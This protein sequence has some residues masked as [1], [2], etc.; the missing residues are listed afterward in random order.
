MRQNI[1]RKE[2]VFYYIKSTWYKGDK[3]TYYD[4][5]D[6]PGTKILKDNY[7]QIKEEIL[8]HFQKNRNEFSTNFT[9]YCLGLDSWIS[10]HFYSYFLKYT[11]NCAK[12]P[13][14]DRV[15]NQ[16]PGMC[17]AMI[18]VIKPHTIIP[19]HIGDTDGF[20]RHHL[21]VQ[22]P[23]KLPEVGF[24]VKTQ[25][26][27]WVEG[28]VFS[29]CVTHRHKAWNLTDKYRIVLLVDP[30]HPDLMHKKYT[31]AGNTIATMPMKYFATKFPVLKKMPLW[32]TKIIHNCFG[33]F[34]R[35]ILFLER[36]FGFH[37]KGFSK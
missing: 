7:P 33:L 17:G 16:I 35:F 14:I 8:E 31:I 12:F 30:I 37:L 9:P 18:S 11:K 20:V 34:F 29:F 26:Q 15:V 28:E 25:D 10:V 4:E 6:F 21:S 23:G 1:K 13:V 3:P 19:T 22:I 36:H 32:M 24:R 27:E 5:N 2:D